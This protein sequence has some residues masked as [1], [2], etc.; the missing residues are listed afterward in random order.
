MK[1]HCLSLIVAVAAVLV[2]TASQVSGQVAGTVTLYE[3]ARLITG[4]PGAVIESSA[5]LVENDRFVRV[6][7]KGEIPLPRGATQGRPDRQDRHADARRASCASRLLQVEH[8]APASS[9]ELHARAAAQRSAAV[10]VLRR[11]HRAQS[12][13]RPPRSRLSG[14]RRMAKNAAAGR[15]ALLHRRPGLCRPECGTGRRASGCRLQ[16]HDR[17]RR[18][19]RTCRSWPRGRSTAGSRS[20]TTRDAA[21]WLPRSSAPSSTRPTRTSCAS[22]RTSTSSRTSRISCAWASTAWRIPRGGRNR[23]SRWTMS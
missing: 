11:G 9:D 21:R 3:G 8:R 20:G 13:R 23:S 15:R 7:K 5:F 18:P 12:R 16:R 14:S 19:G 17:R 22:P 6:G 10:R 1:K 4:E 2:P